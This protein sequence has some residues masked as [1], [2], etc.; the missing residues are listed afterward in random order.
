MPLYNVYLVKDNDRIS[1]HSGLFETEE[2]IMKNLEK[3]YNE[4]VYR[5]K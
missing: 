1:P 4:V 3:K 5:K 2:E